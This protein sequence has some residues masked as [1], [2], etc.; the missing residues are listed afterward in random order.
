MNTLSIFWK[1]EEVA[2]NMR[3]SILLQSPIVFVAMR[4]F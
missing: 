1:N 2:H 4:V 3:D